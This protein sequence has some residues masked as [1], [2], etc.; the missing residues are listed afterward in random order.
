VVVVV[1]VVVVVQW[2]LNLC[3]ISHVVNQSPNN[4]SV[5]MNAA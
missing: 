3:S 2:L 1:V 4:G 5:L